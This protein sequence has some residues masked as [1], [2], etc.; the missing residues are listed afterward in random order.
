M[1]TWAILIEVG[2]PLQGRRQSFSQCG[3]MA[4]GEVCVYDG[5]KACC[6]D[7]SS[8]KIKFSVDGSI[9][10]EAAWHRIPT[11]EEGGQG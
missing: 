2:H 7:M 4:P 6:K 1:Q 8:M 11:L 9:Q 10:E 5:E 3:Q